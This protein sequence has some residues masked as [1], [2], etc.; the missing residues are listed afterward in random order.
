M[1]NP[2]LMIE[3]KRI[4]RYVLIWFSSIF[5]A[6]SLNCIFKRIGKNHS[7]LKLIE[8]ERTPQAGRTWTKLKL[9]ISS[10]RT[11]TFISSW[12]FIS[13][14]C[15]YRLAKCNQVPDNISQTWVSTR[16]TKIW[17]KLMIWDHMD[18]INWASRFCISRPHS[19]LMQRGL[20]M[21]SCFIRHSYRAPDSMI[22]IKVRLGISGVIKLVTSPT[23]SITVLA[24]CPRL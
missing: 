6:E 23:T 2:N 12:R 20:T 18:W 21:L 13:N 15:R 1:G 7:P 8:M 4:S 19:N 5:K 22:K 3:K 9:K 24:R 10:T 11:K 16:L 14:R 17:N